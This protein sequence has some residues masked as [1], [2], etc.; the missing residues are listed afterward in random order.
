MTQID[1][2]QSALFEHTPPK[3]KQA[4]KAPKGK[5]TGVPL[6]APVFGVKSNPGFAPGLKDIDDN[7]M[8][9]AFQNLPF[10]KLGVERG[11][12]T[13]TART[14]A[15]QIAKTVAESSGTLT[16]EG[17]AALMGYSGGGGLADGQSLTA[18][19]T[20]TPLAAY[21]WALVSGLHDGRLKTALEPS[22]GIGAFLLTAPAG[23]KV[24][25][26]EYDTLTANIATLLSPHTHAHNMTFETFTTT[27]VD[28][29]VDV[30]IG[31]PPYGD[32]GRLSGHRGL[33]RTRE[34]RHEWFFLN[35]ALSR[36]KPGGIVA[37]ILPEDLVR[38]EAYSNRRRKLLSRATV[39]GVIGVPTGAFAASN[40]GLMTVILVLRKHDQGVE[41]GLNLL[42]DES[43][44]KTDE[45]GELIRIPSDRERMLRK[46]GAW[47]PAFV[48]GTTT[49]AKKGEEWISVG[50][51][52]AEEVR[53]THSRYGDPQLAGKIEL[54]QPRLDH[55]LA[56]LK[57]RLETAV[58]RSGLLSAVRAEHGQEK[59]LAVQEAMRRASTWPL[60][61][62][63]MSDDELF[64]F[65]HGQWQ[66]ADLMNTPE[67]QTA[68]A[69]ARELTA[70]RLSNLRS[71]KR[72]E[73]TAQLALHDDGKQGERLAKMAAR[74]PL[75]HVVRMPPA[76]PALDTRV[77]LLPGALEDV[78]EQLADLHLL[79]LKQLVS[80]SEE[81]E[82]TCEAHL[83]AE[84]RF[85]GESTE[86]RWIRKGDSDFGHAYD[87][88][89]HLRTLAQSF[90][91]VEAAS[92][93]KQADDFENRALA[94]WKSLPD[95]DLTPR[96]S[97]VPA[98]CLEAWIDA[99]LNLEGE[100]AGVIEVTREG[101]IVS[102]RLR[103]AAD[104]Q[105]A[106]L[107]RSVLDSGTVKGLESY[108]NY[109]TKRDM[110][111]R[112][113]KS[114]EEIRAQEA[115]SLKRASRYER[116]LEAHWRNWIVT[117]QFASELENRYNRARNAVLTAP[118]DVRPMNIE[119]WH[120][121][122]LHLYQR[123]D[124]RTLA[125]WGHGVLNYD[126]GL[127]KT[128]SA[129]ALLSLLKARR[130]ARM[131][132][133]VTPLS[134]T[135]NW[136][137]NVRRA[138]PDWKVVSIGMTPTGKLD[139]FGE[140]EYGED[141]GKVRQEKIASLMSDPPDLVII[142]IE[143][144]VDIPMSHDTLIELIE[145]D[146]GVMA[147]AK[148][149]AA[150]GFDDRKSR[151]GGHKQAVTFE[152][153]VGDMLERSKVSTGS[154]LTF[155]MLGVDLLIFEESHKM[156]NLWSAPQYLGEVPKFMGAGMESRRA[157]GAYHKARYVR[158]SHQGRGTYALTATPWKNS[159]LECMYALALVTDDLRSYGLDTPMS[160]ML[161]YCEIEQQII[162]S[163]DGEVVPQD[164]VE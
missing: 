145:E 89:A 118:E 15:N 81:D 126:V 101:G 91:G 153:E 17:R 40:A 44:T 42:S 30:V 113:D 69:L 106:Y 143:T 25:G 9:L 108:L 133:L 154:D 139:A 76:P 134:L 130:E 46:L 60:P 147:A 159:P 38:E 138:R 87:R 32:R 55:H 19:Y 71:P 82:A 128:F 90:S 162:T 10:P 84:Y 131:A 121:P 45:Q 88:A 148:Q 57:S 52:V 13:P 99:Y 5:K 22:C 93:L 157:L 14:N 140:P 97:V 4:T 94:Q 104:N 107:D 11:F 66:H 7:L 49:F 62:G 23:V 64:R 53:V 80:I 83:L 77:T 12:T 102:L 74:Y 68:I 164:S 122:K 135:G 78:A 119:G 31:N 58:S 111:N 155:E 2:V 79:T 115:A 28:P 48:N 70:E 86:R 51:N 117:S 150:D 35:S 136:V 105:K 34:D 96:D 18:F 50:F 85:S 125:A 33:E 67:A 151:F 16:D 129:L 144:F 163:P 47:S 26:V 65:S 54:T 29:F 27:S 109:A 39:L 95:C 56:N 152:S 137:T 43:S 21:T 100:R 6:T 156:K 24:T 59:E 161:R 73:L 149:A 158:K 123:R 3:P 141:S 120:G 127:G 132:M 146:A 37:L 36:V 98:E 114:R 142:S 110:V 160:F 41:A 103:H 1:P 92:L 112:Q 8:P 61:N 63:F 72:D 116:G 75:L 124:V 20:P